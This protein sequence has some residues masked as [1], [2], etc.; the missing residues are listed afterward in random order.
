MLAPEEVYE[1]PSADLRARGELSHGEKRAAWNKV[2]KAR[3]KTRRA[4]DSDVN[5][6]AKTK[7]A[8][9]IKAQKSAALQNLVKSGKGV[10][11]IG[12]L[13]KNG[14]EREKRTR[15]KAK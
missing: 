14:A 1:R 4:L 12:K 11:V 9:A 8:G 6:F 15:T 7:G 10:T 3:K 5:K 2:K 13:K